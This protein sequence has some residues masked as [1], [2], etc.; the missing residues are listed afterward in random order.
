MTLPTKPATPVPTWAT[1]TNYTNGADVGLPTKV[2]PTTGEKAEGH[3]RGKRPPARK[4]NWLKHWICQWLAWS[5]DA[6]DDLDDRVETTRS[7]VQ[8]ACA[9]DVAPY[10]AFLGQGAS[11]SASIVGGS[12]VGISAA[13]PLSVRYTRYLNTYILSFRLQVTESAPGDKAV[14]VRVPLLSGNIADGSDH[15]L[16]P[17][18]IYNTS[19]GTN[20]SAY[21][22]VMVYGEDGT[23]DILFEWKTPH[24]TG[25]TGV[26]RATVLCYIQ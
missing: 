8:G 23:K 26:I 3:F 13:I 7:F 11:S 21:G 24:E 22:S 25:S 5:E 9:I 17:G 20:P 12:L 10:S 14:K 1:D 6:A 2:E 4:I 15:C 19:D 18:T 16:G